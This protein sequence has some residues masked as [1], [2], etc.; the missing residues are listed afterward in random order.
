M[1]LTLYVA[2]GLGFSAKARALVLPDIVGTLESMGFKV[3]EPFRDNEDVDAQR[4]VQRELS[5]AKANAESVRIADGLVVV[6]SNPVPDEGAMVEVGL[7]L[8]WKKP[9]FV[10]NDD[11]RIA[12][13][14]H[15]LPLNLMIF[16][17]QTQEGWEKFYYTSVEAMRDSS[18]AL[19]QWQGC[20][21]N[22]LSN[23]SLS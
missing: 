10:L 7:A 13:V 5:I 11:F 14:P 6:I 1:P 16:A 8:A 3:I 21:T 4:G 12:P 22:L 15:C 2:N 17:N 9:V 20:T 23:L 18:K 19:A